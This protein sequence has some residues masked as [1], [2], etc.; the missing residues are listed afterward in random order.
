M[1]VRFPL[2]APSQITHTSTTMSEI[3]NPVTPAQTI[4]PSYINDAVTTQTSSEQFR[5]SILD[6][7]VKAAVDAELSRATPIVQEFQSTYLALEKIIANIKPRPQFI[8]GQGQTVFGM[9]TKDHDNK[10]KSEAVLA[11]GLD[12]F[13]K[14]VSGKAKVDELQ[15]WIG[16]AKNITSKAP[17]E[18]KESESDPK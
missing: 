18:P 13:N 10:K 9:S 8:D 14:W 17:T 15:K 16:K 11:E 4:T 2:T 6:R 12:T 3:L 1:R 5:R 7:C